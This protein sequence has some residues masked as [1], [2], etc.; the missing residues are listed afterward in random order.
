VG[1]ALAGLIAAR[2][3]SRLLEGLLYDVRPSDPWALG[4]AVATLTAVAV[5]ASAIPGRAAA[6]VDPMEALKAE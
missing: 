4:G 2:F 6:R 3:L 5:L 1:G